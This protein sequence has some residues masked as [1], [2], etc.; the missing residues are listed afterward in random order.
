M[1]KNLKIA[2]LSVR[3]KHM[4]LKEILILDSNYETLRNKK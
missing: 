2:R 1:I 4:C 3:T